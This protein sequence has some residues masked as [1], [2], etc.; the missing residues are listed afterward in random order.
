[1]NVAENLTRIKGAKDTCIEIAD[2]L[3]IDVVGDKIDIIAEKIPDKIKP[4]DYGLKAIGWTDED[5]AYFNENLPEGY[6]PPE[7]SDYDIQCYTDYMNGTYVLPKVFTSSNAISVKYPN[8]VYCPKFDTSSVT[9][10]IYMFRNC[11]SLVSV[12][13]FDTSSVTSMSLMFQNC[14]SLVSVPQFDTSSATNISYMFR[15]CTA[16][17]TCN[18]YGVKVNFDL[19]YSPLLTVDSLVYIIDNAQTV[20]KITMTLGTTNLA[21]LTTEQIAVATGKGWTLS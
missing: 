19:S 11:T 14:T 5:I 10:M 12:P 4:K 2:I 7:V 21:K 17:E 1:M 16:L 18:L 9:S 15:D 6:E 3:E 13:Q 8:L 20:S